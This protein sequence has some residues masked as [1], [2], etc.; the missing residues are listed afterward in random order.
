MT[1]QVHMVAFEPTGTKESSKEEGE[2]VASEA[3][4]AYHKEEYRR[5]LTRS[6]RA[7]IVH[8][9]HY[10]AWRLLLGVPGPRWTRH[11]G[12]ICC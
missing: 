3:T 2:M 11:F 8:R 9:R 5:G 7:R 4:Q 6:I 1:H 12:S 10:V